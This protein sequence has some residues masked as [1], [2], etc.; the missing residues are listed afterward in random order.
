MRLSMLLAVSDS[1]GTRD[2]PRLEIE[3]RHINLAQRI[4][5][6]EEFSMR[7]FLERAKE[8]SMDPVETKMCNAVANLDG[9]ILR[10]N[11]V[12]VSMRGYRVPQIIPAAKQLIEEGKLE[13]VQT[14]RT[15]RWRQPGHECHDCEH[16]IH[17]EAEQLRH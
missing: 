14:G 15:Q 5:R 2:W 8:T 4:M 1:L 7:L 9:C 3:A 11:F 16:G 10:S 17:I 13:V 6:M 12:R